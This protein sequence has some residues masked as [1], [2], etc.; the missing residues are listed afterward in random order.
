MQTILTTELDCSHERVWEGVRNTH[1]LAYV[2][3]PIL[4]FEPVQPKR[5]PTTWRPANYLVRLKFLGLIPIGLH[6][7]MIS[8]PRR[9]ETG[10][11]QEFV[12]RDNGFG[13]LAKK[14]DH[15]ITIQPTYDGKTRYT[16]EVDI[17]AGLLTLVIWAFS[18]VFYRHRQKRWRELVKCDFNFWKGNEQWNVS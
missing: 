13:K 8:F 7:I 17:E 11:G 16:D 10:Y 5:L 4:Y 18:Q 3:A 12:I 14:W 6:W 2:S 1:L 15:R 9:R